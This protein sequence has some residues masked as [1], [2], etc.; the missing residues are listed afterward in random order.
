ML[1]AESRSG[2]KRLKDVVDYGLRYRDMSNV[3]Y[4]DIDEISRRKGDIHYNQACDL[5]EKRL[6]WSGEDGITAPLEAFCD[7]LGTVGC[8][9]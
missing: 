2:R 4:I 8:D 5:I 7:E 9:R 1:P 6:L 3:L